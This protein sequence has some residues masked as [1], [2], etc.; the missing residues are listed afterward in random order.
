MEIFLNKS[1]SWQ[2][3][4]CKSLKLRLQCHLQCPTINQPTGKAT[5]DGN[6]ECAHHILF[7]SNSPW[8]IYRKLDTAKFV[9]FG[10][11]GNPCF[12]F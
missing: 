4:V 1:P 8:D 12:E 5:D 2:D 10:L 6:V 7:F 11:T 3:L 9:L